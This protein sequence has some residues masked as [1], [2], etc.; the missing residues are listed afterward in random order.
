M[1]AFCWS[2][3][4]PLGRQTASTLRRPFVTS[5]IRMRRPSTSCGQK[6]SLTLLGRYSRDWLTFAKLDV[7]RL[8]QGETER[9]GVDTS[10]LKQLPTLVMFKNGKEIGRIPKRD[11]QGAIPK[12]RLSEDVIVRAFELD[13][14]CAPRTTATPAPKP[15]ETKKKD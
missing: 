7:G 10:D 14:I 8:A 3:C 15:A 1:T 4:L 2:T 12:V 11:T 9:L 5:P 6:S 13:A